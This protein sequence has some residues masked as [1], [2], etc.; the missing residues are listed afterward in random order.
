[1]EKDFIKRVRLIKINGREALIIF[2]DCEQAAEIYK[3]T[4]HKEQY[5]EMN[6][7]AILYLYQQNERITN[8][9]GTE[10][11][12]TF[13]RDIILME[14]RKS[15]ILA[16][17]KFD[18]AR[19]KFAYLYRTILKNCLIDLSRKQRQRYAKRIKTWSEFERQ[20]KQY[21][22][23]FDR[24]II[25][26][27]LHS[28][29]NKE[30]EQ[31]SAKQKD[32]IALMLHISVTNEIAI[33]ALNMSRRNFYYM[34]NNLKGIL[35]PYFRAHKEQQSL[36]NLLSDDNDRAETKAAIAEVFSAGNKHIEK[37][38]NLFNDDEVDYLEPDEIIKH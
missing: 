17:E 25:K 15:I 34:K 14:A 3:D 8:A 38:P 6:Q 28:L 10:F 26:K 21:K 22:D 1:V 27:E 20:Q 35:L 24:R 13:E 31:L 19:G 5:R 12:D 11:I 2:K 16:A 33:Q 30:Y 18:P 4:R 37:K 9:I 29:S 32:Y 36:F 23:I 7:E